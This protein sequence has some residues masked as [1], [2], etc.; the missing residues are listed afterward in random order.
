MEII[1]GFLHCHFRGINYMKDD[2]ENQNISEHAGHLI[3]STKN[4]NFIVCV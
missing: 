2:L 4:Y 1:C 3:Y